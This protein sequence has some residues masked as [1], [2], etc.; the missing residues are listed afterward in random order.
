MPRTESE[1]AYIFLYLIIRLSS[2][3]GTVLSDDVIFE[4]RGLEEFSGCLDTCG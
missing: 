3:E 2:S 1:V 4:N